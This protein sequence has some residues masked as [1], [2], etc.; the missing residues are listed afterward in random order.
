ML[1]TVS[2]CRWGSSYSIRK[3]SW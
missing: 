2:C 1:T 3:W